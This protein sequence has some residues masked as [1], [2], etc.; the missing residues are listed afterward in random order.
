M[1]AAAGIS[2]SWSVGRYTV[3]MTIP[4]SG[5]GLLAATVEWDP[6]LPK[7]LTEAELQQYRAGRD[8]ALADMAG[9]LGITVGLVEL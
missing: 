3:T 9:E 4:R 2:R 5:S 7:R 1:S 6:R 8:A